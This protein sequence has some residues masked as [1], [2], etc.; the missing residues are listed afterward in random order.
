MSDVILDV[1][2]LQVKFRVSKT[3]YLTAIEDVS[4]KVHRKEVLGIVGES[5]CGKS[6]TANAI[7]RL[8][9][10]QTSQISN[11]KIMFQGED[12]AGLSN[13]EMRRIRG[14][15]ISMIFQEPMTSLNPVYRIG[16]QMVEMY[17]AQNKRMSKKE[18]MKKAVEMLDKVGIPSPEERVKD[19]P[20]QLSG[21]MRQRVMIAMALSA[22]PELLIADE[23]TTALDV[24]IQ[25]QVLQLMKQLQEEMDTAVMLITHDMGVVAEIADSVMVMYAGEM[26]EYG[27]VKTIFNRPVHPYTKGLL[28]S[29]TRADRDVDRLSSIEGTVPPL[30][31]MPAGCRFNNRCTVC[32]RHNGRCEHERPALVEVEPN[33]LVR[34]FCCA[35]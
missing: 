6:V 27:D 3:D 16:D 4:F 7:L 30:S 25:A 22:R 33:H 9:P 5:G 28:A 10:P 18:A 12:L 34:C 15:K 17:R 14:N 13:K 29:L 35:E 26:V 24:T 11:G 8:L 20:H 21:G 31:R 32:A 19:F 1:Q 2:N 23:P